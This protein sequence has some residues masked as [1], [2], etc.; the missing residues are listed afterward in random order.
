MGHHAEE[1]AVQI[2]LDAIVEEGQGEGRS[3][4]GGGKEKGGQG[5]VLSS[6]CVKS[7]MT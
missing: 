3:G 6:T 7:R 2:S 5:G 1:R 4:T